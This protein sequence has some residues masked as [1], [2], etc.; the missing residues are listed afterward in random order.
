M[1]GNSRVREQKAGKERRKIKGGRAGSEA[2]LQAT[3]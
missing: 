3:S 2:R 1:Q